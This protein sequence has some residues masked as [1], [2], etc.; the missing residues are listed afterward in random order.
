MKE[1]LIFPI[2][3]SNIIKK[4]MCMC[5]CIYVYV[6]MCMCICV[7]MYISVKACVHAPV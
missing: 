5:T 2:K 1:L 4:Y 7:Y 6:Y 3:I